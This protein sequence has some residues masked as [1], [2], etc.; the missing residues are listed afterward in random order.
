MTS[1]STTAAQ[2]ERDVIPLL[3]PHYRHA[4]RMTADYADAEDLL[5][6][7]MLKAYAAVESLRPCMN[8]KAWLYRIMTNTYKSTVHGRGARARLG[9]GRKTELGSGIHCPKNPN[10]GCG[11]GRDLGARE[12]CVNHSLA[13][14]RSGI[15]P[16]GYRDPFW[17]TG[18]A[19]T[20]RWS[21][22]IR[23]F[24]ACRAGIP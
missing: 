6:E 24:V 5:Q 20:W 14:A 8:L 13:V 2:F 21:H 12:F 19:S 22:R 9:A 4:L 3:E 16:C 23:T 10:H 1:D 11:G 7:A 17:R 18:S 15:D